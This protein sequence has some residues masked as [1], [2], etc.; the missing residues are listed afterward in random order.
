MAREVSEVVSPSTPGAI[1]CV[2]GGKEY[3]IKPLPLKAERK[4]KEAAD[5]H[6]DQLFG[7]IEGA[8]AQEINSSA[9]L[10]PALRAMKHTLFYATDTIL[11][12]VCLYSAVVAGDRERIEEEAYA[13]EVVDAFVQIVGV[14]FPLDRLKSLR[15]LIRTPTSSSSRGRNGS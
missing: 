2:L 15:G 9:D 13:P 8:A 6:V 5:E 7:L 3:E 4:W 11:D 14:V 1:R 12:L 10:M